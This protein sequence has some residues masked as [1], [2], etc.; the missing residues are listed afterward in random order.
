MIQNSGCV[1]NTLCM[2]MTIVAEITIEINYWKQLQVANVK[3]IESVKSH[4]LI[5]KVRN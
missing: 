2:C 4:E 5:L 3:L 1:I